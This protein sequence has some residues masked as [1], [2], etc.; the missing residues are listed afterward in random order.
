[1][2]F[3]EELKGRQPVLYARVSTEEQKK[4]LS[5]QVDILEKWLKDAGITR[6]PKVFKEQVSG[7]VALPPMLGDAIA[8]CAERPGKT[9]LSGET[10]SASAGIG[11]TADRT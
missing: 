9:F 6:K 1:M 7:T 8:Y 2:T 3:K 11:A 5:N 4:T 10:T